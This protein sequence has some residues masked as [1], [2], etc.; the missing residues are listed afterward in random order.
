[1]SSYA[2]T[3]PTAP[4]SGS[5]GDGNLEEAFDKRASLGRDLFWEGGKRLTTA[6]DWLV[7]EGITALRQSI[8]RR[9]I[10]RPG[11]WTVRP[12]YGVGAQDFLYETLTESR[13]AELRARIR[14]QLTQDRRVQKV[15]AV[16]VEQTSAGLLRVRIQIEVQGTIVALKPFLLPEDAP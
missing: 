7:V 9:L 11:E 12:L 1:M 13:A 4:T 8:L 10:T 6:G 5:S 16:F 2:W 14:D 3:L 15:S